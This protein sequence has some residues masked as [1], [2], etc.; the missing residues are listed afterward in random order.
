M[1]R[2][3]FLYLATP[4][5]GLTEYEASQSI[6]HALR[7]YWNAAKKGYSLYSPGLGL[8]FLAGQ[9]IDA[10]I[11]VPAKLAAIRACDVFLFLPYAFDNS[12]EITKDIQ[13]AMAIGKPVFA[14]VPRYD[15]ELDGELGQFKFQRME[16]QAGPI[17]EP[18]LPV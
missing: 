13:Y 6:Y 7:G 4:V 15:T 17:A 10:S 18:A 14:V 1:K 2:T 9:A 5:V 8:S 12:P 11:L 3:R 16:K